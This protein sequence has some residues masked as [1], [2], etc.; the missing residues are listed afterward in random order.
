MD[1]FANSY[2]SLAYPSHIIHNPIDTARRIR[3]VPA[4]MKYIKH[5][6]ACCEQINMAICASEVQQMEVIE[7]IM[8]DIIVQSIAVVV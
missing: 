3:L 4:H 5:K 7:T 6:I 2:T 1:I 8:A